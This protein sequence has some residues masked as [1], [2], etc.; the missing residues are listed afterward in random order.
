MNFREHC[1]HRGRLMRW[2]PLSLSLSLFVPDVHAAAA[3]ASFELCALQCAHRLTQVA[4]L[5]AAGGL[6]CGAAGPRGYGEL[7]ECTRVFVK[8]TRRVFNF[9]TAGYRPLPQR[10]KKP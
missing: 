9:R 3:A 5:R 4:L 7:R 2:R 1:R 10:D 8:I 6:V